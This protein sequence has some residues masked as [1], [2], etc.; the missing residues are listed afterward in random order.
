MFPGHP[1]HGDVGEVEEMR[2][3]MEEYLDKAGVWT[4]E[5]EAE[6]DDKDDAQSI[7]DQSVPHRFING[8]VCFFLHNLETWIHT[9][10]GNPIGLKDVAVPV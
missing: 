7:L 9:H 1:E 6:T 3:Y 10:R 5:A 2:E 4:A 8:E